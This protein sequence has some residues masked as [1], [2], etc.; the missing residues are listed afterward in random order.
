MINK[1]VFA[2][3][4]ALLLT[5]LPEDAQAQ[6]ITDVYLLTGGGD[7]DDG[8]ESNN[9]SGNDWQLL[10]DPRTPSLVVYPDGTQVNTTAAEVPRQLV[11]G[12]LGVYQF[13]YF[14]ED[15]VYVFEA[16]VE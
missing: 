14:A 12:G 4:V 2:L 11:S 3:A 1:Y 13:F 15:M 16:V 10:V 9:M 7:D 5:A 8:G 6:V